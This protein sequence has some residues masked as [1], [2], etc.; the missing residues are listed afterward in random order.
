MPLLVAD[1]RELGKGQGLHRIS[2]GAEL[3]RAEIEDWW[4]FKY[5]AWETQGLVTSSLADTR[6]CNCPLLSRVFSILKR[7]LKA[8]VAV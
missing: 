3:F 1:I 5:S 6:A 8:P 2:L 4:D 7:G